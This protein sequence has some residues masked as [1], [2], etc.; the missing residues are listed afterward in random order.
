MTD[1]WLRAVATNENNF[2][3]FGRVRMLLVL[4][5]QTCLKAWWNIGMYYLAA[6]VDAYP[7]GSSILRAG[8][9][10]I[11]AETMPPVNVTPISDDTADWMT[12]TTINP[13]I[14]QLSR[15]VNVAWQINWSLHTDLPIKSMRKNSTDDVFALQLAWE[16]QKENEDAGF[17]IAGWWCSLDALIRTPD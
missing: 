14:V 13:E 6:D 1:E 5:E 9:A 15:A 10:W 12:I 17:E 2:D 11:N 16:F 7:P 3:Y 4:P 8:V